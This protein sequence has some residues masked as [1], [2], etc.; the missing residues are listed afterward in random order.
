MSFRLADGRVW[1]LLAAEGVHAAAVFGAVCAAVVGFTLW[2]DQRLP[3]EAAVY[4]GLLSVV[5]GAVG[6]CCGYLLP[7]ARSA[8]LAV[9]LA[10]GLRLGALLLFFGSQV[11]SSAPSA[12]AF[13]FVM[14]AGLLV[15]FSAEA[16]LAW[17]PPGSGESS[18]AD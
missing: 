2:G 6:L 10:F 14:L 4:A 3:V 7:G 5:P 8:V 18:Q 15:G 1:R 13:A 11:G 9:A 12:R 16:M 17:R